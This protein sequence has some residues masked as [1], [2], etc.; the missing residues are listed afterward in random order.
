[1]AR[2]SKSPIYIPY[3]RSISVVKKTRLHIEY[4]GGEMTFDPARAEVILFYGATADLPLAALDLLARTGCPAVIHRKHLA[5]PAWIFPGFSSDRDDILSAQIQAREDGRRRRYIARTLLEAKFRGARWLLPAS[6]PPRWTRMTLEELRQVEARNARAYWKSFYARLGRAT[7]TRRRKDNPVTA[8][9]DAVAVYQAGII[10]RWLLY[11]RLSAVHGYLHVQT[12]Y[13]SLAYDLMEPYRDWIDRS[14][15]EAASEGQRDGRKLLEAS[16]ANYKRLLAAPVYCPAT[17]QTVA[18]KILLHGAV[19]AL[20]AYLHGD[21]PRLVLPVEG[22]RAGGRPPATTWKMP[23]ARAG[24][25][26]D[27]DPA[28][29][30]RSA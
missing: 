1:M 21:M 29:A 7:D 28:E 24:F 13:P 12:S 5:A 11:H 14:V 2:K 20:R 6:K 17:R 10:L 3:A 4:N 23:G 30:R 22:P 25:N 8:A 19:L 16:V 18:R 27:G 15:F 9:L 26:T